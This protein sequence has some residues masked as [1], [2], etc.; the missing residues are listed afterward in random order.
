MK[1]EL[2]NCTAD[3]PDDQLFDTFL[4]AA[5]TLDFLKGTNINCDDVQR[6]VDT[7][8]KIIFGYE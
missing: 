4:N 3:I 2:C 7:L 5:D 6:D 1:V 8:S